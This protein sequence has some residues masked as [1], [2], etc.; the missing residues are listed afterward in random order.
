MPKATKEE[1][2]WAYVI[3]REK[4]IDRISKKSPIRAEDWNQYTEHILQLILN[5]ETPIYETKMNAYLEETV[6]KYLLR[7]MI[8]SL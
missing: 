4:F 7:L 3:T 6:A 5:D 8:T 1:L 2:E